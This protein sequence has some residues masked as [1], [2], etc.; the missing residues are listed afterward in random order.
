MKITS[1]LEAH[2]QPKDVYDTGCGD[3]AVY[4][5]S[6]LPDP[7]DLCCMCDTGCGDFAGYDMSPLPDP[8]EPCCVCDTGCGDFAVYDMSPLPDPCEL[9][10]R[11]NRRTLSD[12]E[13]LVYSPMS[14]VGGIV[15]DKDAVYIELGGSHSHTAAAATVTRLQHTTKPLVE[16]P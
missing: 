3:F 16:H 8:C 9:P 11:E 4:D 7:Y 1:A 15:Y 12:R 13:R 14:G 5:M 2:C 10:T 6:P